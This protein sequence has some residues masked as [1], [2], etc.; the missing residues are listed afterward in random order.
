MMTIREDWSDVDATELSDWLAEAWNEYQSSWIVVDRELY[1]LCARKGHDQLE[2]VYAKVAIINR[3][4]AA[5]ITRS[6]AGAG[7]TDAEQRVARLLYDC[8][9]EMSSRLRQ[10]CSLQALSK[11]SMALIVA[12]HGWFAKHVAPSLEGTNLCSFMSK[13]LHFHCPMVPIYDS[14]V[15]EN[16]VK[17][18]GDQVPR[19]TRTDAL[20]ERP[21]VYDPN[22]YWYAGRFLRLWEIV[23]R[24][25][26]DA[27]VKMLDHALWRGASK[28]AR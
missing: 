15:A 6:V 13:Y 18:L 26:P 16:I 12:N 7:Q 8:R 11:Q 14:R 10:L 4:Y 27:T 20:L 23:K 19:F 22:Y 9:D 25:T 21:G 1:G 28:E 2:D 17:V 3:V 5:G 24:A